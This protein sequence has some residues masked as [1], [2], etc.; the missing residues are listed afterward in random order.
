M[1]NSKN[2]GKMFAAVGGAIVGA[3]AVLAGAV[4]MSDRKNQEK[5]KNVLNKAREL[6]KDTKS[7]ME[8]KIEEGKGK[9]Q[10]LANV[11]RNAQKEVKKI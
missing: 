4:A 8:D 7:E 11:A 6:V 5:V 3:G 2:K 1:I 10:K 9:A